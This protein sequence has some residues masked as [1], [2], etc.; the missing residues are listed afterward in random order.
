[1]ATASRPACSA[2]TVAAKGVDFF[3][4]LNPALP[5]VA[6]TRTF[7]VLS[8]IVINVLLNVALTWAMP[9]DSTTFFARFGRAV[10]GL[11]KKNL[12]YQGAPA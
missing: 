3:D 10:F 8:A 12:P 11:A 4:P 2:A 9:S 6:H 1:M 7:P 5:A